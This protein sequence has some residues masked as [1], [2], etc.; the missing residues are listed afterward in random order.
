M[1]PVGSRVRQ[2]SPVDDSLRIGEVEKIEAYGGASTWTAIQWDG[3][4]PGELNWYENATLACLGIRLVTPGG[5][6]A[7]RKDGD[8]ATVLVAN[9]LATLET[10]AGVRLL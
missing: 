4:R 2:I 1:I 3:S 10:S 6:A 7:V 9:A 5:A 8:A